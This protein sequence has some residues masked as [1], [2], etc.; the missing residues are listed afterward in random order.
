ML[1]ISPN[2]EVLVSLIVAPCICIIN[3]LSPTENTE[4]ETTVIVSPEIPLTLEYVLITPEILVLCAKEKTD[5]KT[6]IIKQEI[7]ILCSH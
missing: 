1:V 3:N 7:L 5:R 4:E 2:P 6:K